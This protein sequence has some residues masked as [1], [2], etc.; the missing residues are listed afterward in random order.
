M[1]IPEICQFN[2][3]NILFFITNTLNNVYAKRLYGGLAAGVTRN[4]GRAS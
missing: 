1:K 2:V 4:S 3:S